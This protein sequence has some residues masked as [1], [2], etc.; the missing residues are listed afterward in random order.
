MKKVKSEEMGRVV[1]VLTKSFD[2]EPLMNWMIKQDEQRP[3]RLSR[4]LTV[5]AN[6]AAPYKESY[7]SD[8]GS[9]ATIWFPP[10]KK[11][12]PWGLVQMLALLVRDSG[13]RR[14]PQTLKVLGDVEKMHREKDFYL[15][16]YIGVVP[17]MQRRGIGSGLI[18][19][20]LQKAKEEKVKVY[21]ETAD[22][23]NLPFYQRNVFS[24][25]D[26]YEIP[27]GPKIW[28]LEFN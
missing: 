12:S 6:V 28:F 19:P 20:M 24:I 27:D 3:E 11:P 5:A 18:A 14:L 9:G 1:D 16:W 26:Q 21:V 7:L 10:G 23:A 17:N 2:Q 15:L 8:C 4:I 22:P 25:Y 13:I